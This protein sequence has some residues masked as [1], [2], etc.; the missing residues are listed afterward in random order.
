MPILKRL[1]IRIKEYLRALACAP[2][3]SKYSFCLNIENADCELSREAFLTKIW[4][5]SA[6]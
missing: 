2:I 6:S 4:L 1:P 5:L 3:F